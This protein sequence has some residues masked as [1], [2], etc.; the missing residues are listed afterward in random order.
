MTGHKEQSCERSLAAI[1]L[2]TINWGTFLAAFQKWG[3]ALRSILFPLAQVK[4][5]IPS[6]FH[7]Y[8]KGFSVECTTASA[9]GGHTAT[10]CSS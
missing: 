8:E 10:P 5:R 6:Q 7:E 4:R 2:C 3:L 9:A 1:R